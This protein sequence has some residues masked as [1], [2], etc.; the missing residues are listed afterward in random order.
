VTASLHHVRTLPSHRRPLPACGLAVV[1]LLGATLFDPATGRTAEEAGSAS[2]R[3]LAKI[4]ELGGEVPLGWSWGGKRRYEY[5]RLAITL[6]PSWKGGNEGLTHLRAVPRVYE[7]ILDSPSINDDGLRHLQDVQHLGG[8]RAE[9]TVIT[10]AGL[11]KSTTQPWSTWPVFLNCAGWTSPA[12][13]SAGRAW[14]TWRR[15]RGCR[16]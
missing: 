12:R 3:A 6:G 9:S 13:R 7:L 10:D 5:R 2:D 15:C 14:R 8:L 4:E 16:N 1:L 11:H